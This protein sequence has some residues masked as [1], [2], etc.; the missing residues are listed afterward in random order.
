MVQVFRVRHQVDLKMI[1]EFG[2][3]RVG[4]LFT[5]KSTL[6]ENDSGHFG[7]WNFNLVGASPFSSCSSKG[8]S[9]ISVV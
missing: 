7:H 1:R 9:F 4:Y 3:V 5:F 6:R 2:K 8:L